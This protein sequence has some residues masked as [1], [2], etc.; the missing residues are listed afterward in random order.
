MRPWEFIEGKLRDQF[1]VML[2][3]VVQSSGSSPGRQTFKMAVAS[4]GTWDG[5]IGGG[6]ME[7]KMVEL[8]LHQLKQGKATIQCIKQYHDKSHAHGQSGM[9]CSGEQSIAFVP[10]TEQDLELISAII[11]TLEKAEVATLSITPAGLSVCAGKQHVKFGYTDEKNW[12]YQEPIHRG[13]KIHII[14]AGHVGL[15][16]SEVMSMLGFFVALYDD[17]SGLSTF[18][19]NTFADEKHI[20][21]YSNLSGIFAGDQDDYVV[22]ATFGY[23]TDKAALLQLL[24]KPFRY[25]GMLGS[26]AKIVQLFQEMEQ[27]GVDPQRWR[28]VKAPIGHQIFSKTAHEIA[29]SIAAEIIHEKNKDLP[30]GRNINSSGRP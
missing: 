27:E 9:I 5:T 30:T 23:R 10:L 14:G 12:S 28:H 24:D 17:R 1:H 13:P 19:K 3:C 22:I 26:D 7:H 15:A 21:D 6:I 25:I 4:D 2:I 8:S 11:N 29:I 20:I 18:S 16:L